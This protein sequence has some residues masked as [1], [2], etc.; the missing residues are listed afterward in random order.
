M[1]EFQGKRQIKRL[2]YSRGFSLILF[3]LVV[4]MAHSVW[5]IWQRSRLVA[6]GRDDMAA[7]VAALAARE[8]VLKSDLAALDSER[9]REAVIRQKFAVIKEG[10]GVVTVVTPPAPTSTVA[11]TSRTWWQ[12]LLHLDN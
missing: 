7:Q 11:S 4:L 8:A 9:G 10:E 6:A 2:L 1:R 12:K 3:V 5:Q